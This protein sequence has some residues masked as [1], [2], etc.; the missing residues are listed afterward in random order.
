M[1][2]WDLKVCMFKEDK[3]HLTSVGRLFQIELPLK[4]KVCFPGFMLKDGIT[5]VLED[6]LCVFWEWTLEVYTNL[7]EREDGAS[8]LRHLKTIKRS[9]F[10]HL[11]SSLSQFKVIIK[12]SMEVLISA[13]K[14]TRASL[15]SWGFAWLYFSFFFSLV[16]LVLV[17]L[18]CRWHGTKVSS[19]SFSA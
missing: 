6:W 5:S 15:L 19:A 9:C 7:D 3:L 13:D 8:C 1:K 2:T 14:S 4:V 10:C 16:V 18:E 12:S 17:Q 11:L